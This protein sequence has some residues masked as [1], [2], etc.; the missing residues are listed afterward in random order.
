MI[1]NQ[2]LIIIMRL[3][4]TST[5]TVV[6][7]LFTSYSLP[8]NQDQDLL[9]VA[10]LPLGVALIKNSKF[11]I[12]YHACSLFIH[13]YCTLRYLTDIIMPRHYYCA[14]RPNHQLPSL[15]PP[16]QPIKKS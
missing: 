4:G 2:Y 14:T 6:R 16:C 15:Y 3:R 7:Y 5:V 1:I 12:P 10:V 8:L 13:Y 9:A 11:R